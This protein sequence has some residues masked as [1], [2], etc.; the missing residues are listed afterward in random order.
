MGC[1][2]ERNLIQSEEKKKLIRISAYN[3]FNYFSVC[4]IES[5]L[6]FIFVK[7]RAEF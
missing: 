5:F 4:I 6:N 7:K 3:C 2:S 1:A